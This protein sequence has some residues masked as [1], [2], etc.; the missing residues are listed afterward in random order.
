MKF[1]LRILILITIVTAAFIACRRENDKPT[2]D[3]ELLAPLVKTSLTAANIFP[4]SL[5]SIAPKGAMSL[6]Y[7]KDIYSTPADSVFKIQD[8]TI[9]TFQPNYF[10]DTIPPGFYL[11]FSPTFDLTIHGVELSEAIVKK[12]FIHLTIA[13]HLQ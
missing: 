2:W 10:P 6:V 8:T 4:D 11:P 5:T 9:W 3:V 13:N 1:F 7:D 12:G